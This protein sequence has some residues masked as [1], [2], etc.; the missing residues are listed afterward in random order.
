ML[1]KTVLW[2]IAATSPRGTTIGSST[3][4]AAWTESGSPVRAGGIAAR[5]AIEAARPASAGKKLRKAGGLATH[6]DDSLNVRVPQDS[7]V[8]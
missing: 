1:Y 3:C 8:V 4:A 7:S 2:L 6:V 5:T